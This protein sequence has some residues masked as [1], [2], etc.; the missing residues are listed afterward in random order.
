MHFTGM[1]TVHKFIILLYKM[2]I[3]TKHFNNKNLELI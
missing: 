1:L 2:I 3:N